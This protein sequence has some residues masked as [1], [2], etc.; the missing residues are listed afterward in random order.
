MDLLK[1]FDE[2]NDCIEA[3]QKSVAAW[4]AAPD[5]YS[6]LEDRAAALKAGLEK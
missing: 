3:V 4:D 6:H 1:A 2:M 5:N